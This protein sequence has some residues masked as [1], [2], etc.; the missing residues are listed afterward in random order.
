MFRLNP[1]IQRL[2]NGP[3]LTLLKRAE[4]KRIKITAYLSVI[5]VFIAIA[6]WFVDL[7]SG[8]LYSAPSYAV[9]MINAMAVLFFL[10]R[11]K[12]TL[13]KVLLVVTINLVVFYA[14]ITDPFGSGAFML[15]V[16]S[17]VASFAIL[18]FQER[19]KSYYLA[20]L[21]SVLFLVSYAGEIDLGNARPPDSY[22]KLSFI[23]NYVIS[24]ISAVLVLYFL[25]E[26]NSESE[27]ELMNKERAVTEKNKQLTKVNQE[28]DRFVYS[29]SHDLR[30]PLS[31]IMGIINLTKYA[32]T[33]EELMEL[34]QLIE[35]RVSAQEKFIGE[36]ISYSRNS[37]TRVEKIRVSLT[38]VVNEV[39][40]SLRFLPGSGAIDFRIEDND[41]LQ[42]LVD[43][44]RLKVILLNL[45]SN[46]IKYQDPNKTNPF[47]SVSLREE[48]RHVAIVVADNGVGI[49]EEHLHKIFDM[50]YRASEASTGSGL[51]LYIAQEVVEKLGG[52]LS[53]KS[54]LGEGTTFTVRLRA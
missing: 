26:L 54:R 37:R 7:S 6:Y 3:E 34:I 32:G 29:V 24:I 17:G 23:L 2:I 13:A 41:T 51:G 31:S 9:L 46:A 42:L 15:F 49:A 21:T 40:E 50:F 20:L 47:V 5:C 27:Q 11:G 48:K 18:G 14:S 1:F 39:L 22:I 25:V 52:T 44:T 53:V 30:S 38:D 4:Y 28:L 35:G 33:K 10:R 12:F 19:V 36:I 8:V 43:R 16:S 45:I